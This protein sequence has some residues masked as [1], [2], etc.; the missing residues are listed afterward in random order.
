MNPSQP[1]PPLSRFAIAVRSG[2]SRWPAWT[3]AAVAV[4]LIVPILSI[5]I[6]MVTG[7][8]GAWSH[9]A[10]TVLPDLIANSLLLAALVAVGVGLVGTICAWLTAN[11]EFPG[12]TAF[13]WL[14]ILP[15]AMPAYVMAYTYTDV[16]QYAG[17]LQT[18]LRETFGWQLKTDYWFPEI[19]SLGGAAAMLTFVLY[20][21]VYMLARVAFLEQSA[22]MTEAGRTFGFG[23]MRIFWRISLPLARPAIA[24]G[25][26]LALME[27]LADY[28]TVSYFGVPT[29]T[30]GIFNAWFSQGDRVSAGKLAM[31]LLVFVV[32]ILLVEHAARRRARFF[33]AGHRHAR[34][35]LQG[36]MRWLAS[37]ACLFP[38]LIGFAVPTLI[39]I[40]LAL[41]EG[42]ATF[43][44]RFIKLA[45]NSF[46]AA[47]LTALLA[48][49]VALLLAYAARLSDSLINRVVNR[50]VG[51]GYAIP[52]TVIAVGILI[53]VAQLDHG[54]VAMLE[55]VSGASVP[56]LLTGSI[57]AL[58]YAYLIRFL[59]VALQS[60]EAGLTK[61]TPSMDDAARSLGAGAAG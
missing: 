37:A 52:G 36:S 4:L 54:L 55:S 6:S 29:F 40:K 26:A 8:G 13:E 28:G 2:R 33:Q 58:I 60:V 45:F 39:L 19:R 3:G 61:I 38:L 57:A 27:T 34:A 51:L 24:A 49:C 47:A 10:R 9:I 32:V 15:L 18:A 22:S 41:V 14:L 12:R 35:P 53:P 56:L 5:A 43:G 21:Y 50:V 48:V 44:T 1:L 16:L 30:T 59:G 7:D 23:R 20:P 31:I 46:G 25:I 11:H 17:P 42:D